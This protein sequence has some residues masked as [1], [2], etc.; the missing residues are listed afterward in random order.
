MYV[1]EKE[2]KEDYRSSCFGC[3]YND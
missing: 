1:K 2:A 3:A